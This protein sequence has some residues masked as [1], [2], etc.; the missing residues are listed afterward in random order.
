MVEK[1]INI[2]Y[3]TL[4]ELLRR[5][6]TREEIQKI[7][8]GFFDNVIVYLKEEREL[9]KKLRIKQ[10]LFAS[11]ELRKAEIK[12]ENVRK[13]IRELYEKRER[14]II[15]LALDC[16]RTDASI[17]DTSHLLKEEKVF[18]ECIVELFNRFRKGLLFNLLRGEKIDDSVCSIKVKED[19]KFEEENNINL[20]EPGAD[21]DGLIV[22]NLIK[23]KFAAEIPKFVG[24]DMKEY[25]PYSAGQIE[26]IPTAIAD[27]FLKSGN[28]E[29]VG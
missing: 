18:Y 20:I 24:Q 19:D 6:K 12:D 22:E 25:G 29:K 10:D 8:D 17:I 13:I 11:E 26:D 9:I 21:S 1:E 14:K 4:F 16:S 2:A 23:L 28:A 3:E 5:E 15:N 27:I 7:D